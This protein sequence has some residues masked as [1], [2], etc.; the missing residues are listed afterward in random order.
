MEEGRKQH[1]RLTGSETLY[2]FSAEERKEET[3]EEKQ[4]YDKKHKEKE[5]RKRTK[6]KGK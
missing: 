5:R 3:K 2:M 4:I 1:E 6:H